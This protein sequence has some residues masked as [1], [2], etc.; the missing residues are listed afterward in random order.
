MKRKQYILFCKKL[1]VIL[2]AIIALDRCLGSFIS[3]LYFTEPQ[4][5]SS[6]TTTALERTTADVLVFGSSRA[7]HHYDTKFLSEKTGMSFLNCGKDGIGIRYTNIILPE[8]LK[9]YKPKMIIFDANINEL[10]WKAGKEGDDIILT[11]L[12]PYISNNNEIEVSLKKI[13]DLEVLKSKVSLLYRFNSMLFSI[14]QH[15]FGIGQKNINGF[16]PLEGTTITG[17]KAIFSKDSVVKSDSNLKSDFINFIK[18]CQENNIKLKVLT[19]PIFGNKNIESTKS[20]MLDILK[21]N[22]VE[23]FDFSQDS[24]ISNSIYFKDHNHLNIEGVKIFNE[25]IFTSVID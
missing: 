2:T 23:Y 7:S 18:I 14:V 22:K 13:D 1:L 5:E 9:R 12:M 24:D 25:K 17:S 21:L 20:E 8:V 4:G 11:S 3:N 10:T 6:V 19:S 15:H 16:L